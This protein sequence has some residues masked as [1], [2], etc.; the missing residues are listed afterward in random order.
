MNSGRDWGSLKR[1]GRDVVQTEQSGTNIKDLVWIERSI[2]GIG[3]L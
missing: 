3:S 1:I 2:T